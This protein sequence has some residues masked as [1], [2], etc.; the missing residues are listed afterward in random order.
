[1]KTKNL[2]DE[3][4]YNLLLSQKLPFQKQEHFERFLKTASEKEV[5]RYFSKNPYYIEEEQHIAFVRSVPVKALRKY[6]DGSV[7]GIFSS[8]NIAMEVI[9][10][11]DHDSIMLFLENSDFNNFPSGIAVPIIKRNNADEV[12]K[13]LIRCRLSDEAKIALLEFDRLND[14]NE[15]GHFYSYH[16]SLPEKV[17]I[18]LVKEGTFKQIKSYFTTKLYYRDIDYKYKSIRYE[19]VLSTLLKRGDMFERLV[20]VA[21]H[22]EIWCGQ[23]LMKEASHE[24]LMCWL[25]KD[26][27]LNEETLSLLIARKNVD[28]L[29][30]LKHHFHCIHISD[31]DISNII[32]FGNETLVRWLCEEFSSAY[33]KDEHAYQILKKG[34]HHLFR[35]LIKSDRNCV[36]GSGMISAVIKAG[37][38]EDMLCVLDCLKV[39]YPKTY[40][41]VISSGN[42]KWIEMYRKKFGLPAIHF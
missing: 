23:C 41:M 2:T 20:K 37:N 12:K 6:L 11:G 10:R 40:A 9:A 38:E 19:S 7:Q 29:L 26:I 35:E 27:Q 34:W 22:L 32:S 5:L 25:S 30:V 17:E 3:Q 39:Y 36:T 14:T 13:L 24:Q 42:P 1:M 33:L 4:I 15:I 21:P 8:F 28:E 31:S 18:A 16:E